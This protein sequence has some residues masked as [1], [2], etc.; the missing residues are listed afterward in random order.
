MTGSVTPQHLLTIEE[1]LK[2]EESAAVRHE[3]VGGLIYAMV[4]ATKRH[5]RIAGKIYRRLADAAEGGPCRV[6]METV[7]VRA[8]S[9]AIYYYPDV[10]VA[11]GPEDDDPLVEHEPCLIVEVTSPSTE[12]IDRREKAFTYRKI[13]TLKAYLIVNQNRRWVE[14]HWCDDKGEW[15]RGDL[16]DAGELPIP[17]PKTKLSLDDIYEGL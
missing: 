12:S 9:D 5:N 7:K 14:W 11:C 3:Y 1:Y 8:A 16:V 17:C 13:P 10:M 2:L 15:Q 6:Y 4:G